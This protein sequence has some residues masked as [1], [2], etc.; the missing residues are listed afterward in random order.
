M[1]LLKLAALR[2]SKMI[3][4]QDY[5]KIKSIIDRVIRFGNAGFSRTLQN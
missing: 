4:E 1:V 5:E 2:K 3:S